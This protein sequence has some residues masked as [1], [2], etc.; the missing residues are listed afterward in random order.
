MNLRIQ[1][2]ITSGGSYTVLLG[3][4]ISLVRVRPENAAGEDVLTN[5][6][7]GI[8]F[9]CC[10]TLPTAHAHRQAVGSSY[11]CPNLR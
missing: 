1:D 2:V 10:Q 6:V 4:L 9:S 11:K 3:Y 5:Y 8:I 7:Y